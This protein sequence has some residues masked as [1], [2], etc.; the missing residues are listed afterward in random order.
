MAEDNKT[1]QKVAR[2][3]LERMGFS[4]DIVENGRDVLSAVQ[5]T[6]YALILM[7]VEMPIMDGIEATQQLRGLPGSV[8]NIPIVAMTAHALKGFQDRCL[9]A[10]MNAYLAKPINPR[11]LASTLA[12]FVNAPGTAAHS[13]SLPPPAPLPSAIGSEVFDA[14][15]L[16][17]QTGGDDDF[18]QQVLA[19]YICDT[20]DRL[21]QLG[22]AIESCNPER[23]RKESHAIKGASSTM[24]MREM[25]SLSS[26]LERKAGLGI[27]TGLDADLQLLHAAFARIRQ[28]APPA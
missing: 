3:M 1:N 10:G 2:A 18:L 20:E 7:D 6:P 16:A 23:I 26:E 12:Q 13:A 21:S 25:Q 28:Q 4:V 15:A 9:K 24:C 19:T 17:E 8:R 14:K 22:A 11:E 27:M 5:K